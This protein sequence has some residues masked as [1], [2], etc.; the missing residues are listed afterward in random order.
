MI[1]IVAVII[2][3]N[4]QEIF[5]VLVFFFLL[6]RSHWGLYYNAGSWL[7]QV[8]LGL[9]LTRVDGNIYHRPNSFEADYVSN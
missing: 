9:T 8:I 4:I 7:I 3:T 5:L 6:M 2:I 1:I